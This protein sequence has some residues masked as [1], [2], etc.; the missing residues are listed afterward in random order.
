MPDAHT[1]ERQFK[2]SE[3]ARLLGVSADWLREAERRGLIPP[4]ARD[5]YTEH[6]IYTTQDLDR[7]RA[8]G[9]GSR[10]RVREPEELLR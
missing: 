4:A 7:L 3:A 8:I 1:E 6:R 2:V 5:F 10:G 9:I